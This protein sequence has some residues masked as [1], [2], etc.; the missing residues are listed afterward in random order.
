MLGLG[1]GFRVR[2]RIRIIT[3]WHVVTHSV[4]S[5]VEIM[6]HQSWVMF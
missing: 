3:D 5:H 4:D 6:S 2:V 1:S